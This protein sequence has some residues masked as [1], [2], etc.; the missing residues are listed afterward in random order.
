[1]N[2]K[3][4]CIFIADSHLPADDSV[5]QF[6]EML[7]RVAETSCSIV[8]LGDIFELW[9]AYPSYEFPIHKK[10]LEWCRQEK[11][12]RI[13]GFI[14]GNHEFYVTARYADSFSWGTDDSKLIDDEKLLLMHGDTI[15]RADTG[16][17]LLRSP[18]RNP[19]FRFL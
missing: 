11:K 1:M 2:A 16:A 7:D 5:P 13:I 10:F 6:F 3:A 12:N 17:C 19:V 8:F 4:P 9:I 14:E 15:N 18:L